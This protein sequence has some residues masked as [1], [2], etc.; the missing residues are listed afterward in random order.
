MQSGDR[1]SQRLVSMHDFGTGKGFDFLIR[2]FFQQEQSHPATHMRGK[3]QERERERER[4]TRDQRT[5]EMET[6]GQ[7]VLMPIIEYVK[8]DRNTTIWRNVDDIWGDDVKCER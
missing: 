3:E 4:D 6:L 1:P 5:Q 8:T 2:K 7:F